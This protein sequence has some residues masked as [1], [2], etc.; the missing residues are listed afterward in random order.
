MLQLKVTQVGN[1]IGVI[2][3]KESLSRL[4]VEK[5]D[6]VYLVES[7]DGYT[8]TAYDPD[9]AEELA[10]AEEGAQKYKNAL[11]ELAK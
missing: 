3:P 9:F 1:S 6:T 7:P 8:L 11:R 2:L 10:F 4:N 5:G